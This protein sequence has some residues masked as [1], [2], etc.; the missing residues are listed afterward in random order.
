MKMRWIILVLAGTCLLA[1]CGTSPSSSSPPPPPSEAVLSSASTDD[2]RMSVVPR[3][4]SPGGSFELRIDVPSEVEWGLYTEL[5]NHVD[6]KWKLVRVFF[7]DPSRTRPLRLYGPT[8]DFVPAIAFPGSED[9]EV[10]IP[11]DL[12]PGR[13][14]IVKEFDFEIKYATF[15]VRP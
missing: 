1:A 4:V 14:R 10:L 13:Y 3:S 15:R 12:A 9:F 8:D 7:T 11:N 6:R 5:E 2:V